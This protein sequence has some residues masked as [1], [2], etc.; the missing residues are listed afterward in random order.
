MALRPCTGFPADF[1]QTSSNRSHA[2]TSSSWTYVWSNA[3]PDIYIKRLKLKK[4]FNELKGYSV[5]VLGFILDIA[6]D[7]EK[8]RDAFV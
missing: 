8:R 6:V 1:Q 7:M 2:F 5:W 4:T 3:S